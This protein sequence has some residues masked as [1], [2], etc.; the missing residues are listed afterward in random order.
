MLGGD[1]R[2]AVEA[3]A[4][5]GGVS[6]PIDLDAAAA[7]VEA[8]VVP[9]LDQPLGDIAY[10]EVLDAAIQTSIRHRIRLPRELVAVVKQVLYFERYAKALAPDYNMARDIFLLKN[11]FPEAVAAKAAE[12]GITF[13]D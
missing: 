5:L 2:A 12:L 11:I 9:L 6:G 1:F 13:P 3:F 4:A 7:D 10:G 8:A